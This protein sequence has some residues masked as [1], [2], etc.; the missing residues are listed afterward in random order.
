MR[1]DWGDE[2]SATG[3]HDGRAAAAPLAE[4][5]PDVFISILQRAKHTHTHI[6]SLISFSS[7]VTREGVRAQRFMVLVDAPVVL[8]VV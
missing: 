4:M 1:L 3:M 7:R 5:G 6:E 8:G 2:E